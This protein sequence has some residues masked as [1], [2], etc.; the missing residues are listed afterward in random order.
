MGYEFDGEFKRRGSDSAK[1]GRFSDEILPMFVADM[2]FKAPEP[3]LKALH[4]RVDHGF[5]GYN[6]PPADFIEVVTARLKNLYGWEVAAEALMPVPG[7]IP[8]FNLAVKALAESGDGILVHVPTYPPI[9]HCPVGHDMVRCD[10]LLVDGPDGFRVD[11]D[12]M[13]EAASNSR[14]FLLCN[15]HNPTGRVF[16]REELERMAEICLRNDLLIISDEIHCDIVFSGSTHIPIATLGP[17]VEERTVTLIAPSKT[18]GLPGLKAA[19]AIVTNEETRDKMNH[20]R[21]GMVSGV[22]LLGFTA[23]VAAY[24]DCQDWVDEM[25]V[26]L[27]ANRDFLEEYVATNMPGVRMH[28]PEGTYLTWLDCGDASLPDDDAREFFRANAQVGVSGGLDFGPAGRGF[29]RLCFA[30]TRAALTR[31]LDRMA[32][33]LRSR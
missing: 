22:N 29:T 13:E 14:I 6:R 28:S 9:Y 33:A 31:A 3:I 27:E 30:T 16:T 11:W 23:L 19:V 4:T 7:V 15:P 25:N 20:S 17:E 21:A 24:R 32:D 5:F 8:G 26:Y 10:S 2:D 1:W 18:F 12:A